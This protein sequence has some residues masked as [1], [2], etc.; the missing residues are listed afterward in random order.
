MNWFDIMCMWLGR[1]Q[2]YALFLFIVWCGF[3][4]VHAE[5]L[6]RDADGY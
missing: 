2:I 5:K 3:C 4:I 1:V 6:R